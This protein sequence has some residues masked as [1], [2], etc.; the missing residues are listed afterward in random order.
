MT[1]VYKIAEGVPCRACG[2]VLAPAHNNEWGLC[3]HCWT[4]L[5]GFAGVNFDKRR[6]E[7]DY[8]I[9]DDAKVNEWLASELVK[10]VKRLKKNGIAGRCEAL[11]GWAYGTPGS[12]CGHVATKYRDGRRV[13]S[14]HARATNPVFVGDRES[15]PYE[16]IRDAMAS[17]AE[18]DPRFAEVVREVAK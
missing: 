9:I 1:A 4:K 7:W 17:L 13:C 15:D 2:A 3:D 16:V 11:S 18:V 8:S 6:G 5:S 14:L 10:T 12:Q